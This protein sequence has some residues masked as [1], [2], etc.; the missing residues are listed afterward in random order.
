MV[1][2][3]NLHDVDAVR[4]ARNDAN[5]GAVQRLGLTVKLVSFQRGNDVNRCSGQPHTAGNKLHG[6]RLARTGSAEDCHVRVFV[7]VGVEV[8]EAD[9][10]VVVL[11]YA[12]QH[13][14]CIA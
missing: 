11:V 6:E 13:A 14:V 8:V 2:F 12:Q 7:D 10:G 3:A 5:N 4:T 9:K 1:D